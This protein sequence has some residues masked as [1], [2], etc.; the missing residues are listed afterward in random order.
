MANDLDCSY[1]GDFGGS[2]DSLSRQPLHSVTPSNLPG[3]PNL[4]GEV[5][6][7]EAGFKVEFGE[8]SALDSFMDATRGFSS[9]N[10]SA[11]GPVE[12]PGEAFDRFMQNSLGGKI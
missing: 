10:T 8:S 6:Q 7:L 12:A 9:I 2:K 4:G 1:T 3:P 11:P 5:G